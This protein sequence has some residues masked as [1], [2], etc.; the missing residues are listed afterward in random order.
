MISVKGL[1]KF[2]PEKK[3]VFQRLAATSPQTTDPQAIDPRQ[4]GDGFWAVRN[5]DFNVED[6]EVLGMLGPNGAGKTTTLRLLSTALAPTHG[7]I[8]INDVNVIENPLEAR[9]KLGFLSGTT[10]LYHRFSVRE[11]VEY[12]GRLHKITEDV[13]QARIDHLFEILEMGSFQHKRVEKI[14]TGMKQKTAIARTVIHEPELLI[15][16]EPTTGLDVMAAKT[17]MDFM[18]DYQK[19]RIPVIFSTHNLHEI[20]KLCENIVVINVG[21]SSYFGSVEQFRNEHESHQLYDAFTKHVSANP[22]KGETANV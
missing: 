5:V 20:E 2:F 1:G 17:I 8:L 7:S 9:A 15:F 18:A 14:S 11:N 6:G 21:E 3:S 10:G 16:D 4:A 19:K 12:Y 22:K 13:L